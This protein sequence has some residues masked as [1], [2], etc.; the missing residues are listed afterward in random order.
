M[1]D[2]QPTRPALEDPPAIGATGAEVGR[3]AAEEEEVFE[4]FELEEVL[5]DFAGTVVSV[6]ASVDEPA[7]R[8]RDCFLYQPISE[9]QQTLE[10][11]IRYTDQHRG[12]RSQRLE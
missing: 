12:E 6:E 5:D 11:S 8:S 1:V 10:S 4:T 3:A 7:A 2:A 9:S